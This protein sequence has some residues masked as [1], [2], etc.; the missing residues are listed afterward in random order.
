MRAPATS[1]AELAAMKNAA[2]R[3]FLAA[4]AKHA[5]PATMCD[6]WWSD[7]LIAIDG[8]PE[9]VQAVMLART[10]QLFRLL[11]DRQCWLLERDGEGRIVAP[12]D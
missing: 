11:I 2:R 10:E 4:K 12:A 9:R 5:A 7:V 3:A 6:L 8:A 1:P